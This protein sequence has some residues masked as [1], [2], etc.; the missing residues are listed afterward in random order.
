M[1]FSGCS[2]SEPEESPIDRWIETLLIICNPLAPAPD[3]VATL[4]IQSRGVNPPGELPDFSWSVDAGSLFV[5]DGITTEWRVPAATGLYSVRVTASVEG[6]TDT[7]TRHVMVRNFEL[8][9]TDPVDVD[10]R[11]NMKPMVL[12]SGSLLFIGARYSEA[13]RYFGGFGVFEKYTTVTQKTV[14]PELGNMF[15]ATFHI[16][17]EGNRFL[18]SIYSG[19]LSIN[20]PQMNMFHFPILGF[21]ESGVMVTDDRDGASAIRRNQ[22]LTPYGYFLDDGL[23]LWLNKFVWQR[24]LAGPADDGTEDLHDIVYTN[25]VVSEEPSYLV[26]TTS[27]DSTVDYQYT[28]PDVTHRYYRNSMPMISPDGEML[29]YFVDTTDVFEPCLIPIVSDVPD[30]LQRRAVMVSENMGIFAEA[31]LS[32][33]EST[34]FEWN[35]AYPNIL[36]FVD[37]MG[38]IGIFDITAEMV[39]KVADV[40]GATEL[41]WSNDGSMCA[42]VEKDG[43]YLISV[44]GVK[45]GNAVF[46]KELQGDG[47]FGINFSPDDDNLTLAFRLVR[48]GKTTVEA[49]AAL[50]VVYLFD[51]SESWCYVSPRVPYAGCFEY[52][53]I[54]YSWFRVCFE[55]DNTGIYAPFPVAD[56]GTKE[57]LIYHSFE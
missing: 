18:S 30:T 46:E 10:L 38:N 37:G 15:G 44:G 52:E 36:G 39:Q 23:G 13:S 49:F 6:K 57:I 50:V 2:E 32:V 17:P 29:V 53:D 7:M 11:L 5:D 20:Q 3:Q 19:S 9:D 27:H 25:D 35:P 41:V 12:Q 45:G 14:H 51:D 33:S 16:E 47:I 28:P 4:T 1:L 31:G 56:M 40:S 24:H 22:H 55:S 21:G 48:M 43:I 8:V 54:N 42:V 26:L 34:V